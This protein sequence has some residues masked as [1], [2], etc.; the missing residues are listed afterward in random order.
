MTAPRERHRAARLPGRG[1]RV[2]AS[3]RRAST[4]RCS[5]AD[6]G[7]A[8]AASSPTNRAQA[9]PVARLARA[10]RGGPRARGRRQRR[11][12]QRRHRRA[13]A[14][15]T[16]ATMAAL[17]ARELGCRAGRGAGRLDRRDR[18]ARCRWSKRAR[19]HR[20]R[21][22]RALAA[23]AAR[24]AARA[25]LTTDTHAKEVVVEFPLGRRDARASAAM[26]KGAGMIAPNMATMLAFF[27]T[28]AA[29]EPAPAARGA[30]RGRGREP[31]PHHRRRRHLDQRHGRDPGQ[32]RAAGAPAITRR[33][34]ATTTPSAARSPRPR[35]R[36]RE[37][38]V[39]DGEG[40]TRV[41]EVRVEGA[42]HD[43]RRRPH[44]AHRGRVAAREDR[45]PRRRPEL[46]PRP[47]RRGPR[48]ASTLDIEPA[49]TS[50]WATSGSREGGAAR[51]YDEA[52]ARRARCSRIRCGSAIRLARGRR[53]SGWIW[54]CDL[55]H[56]YVDINAHYRS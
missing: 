1:G 46:G 56:G 44:R 15:P 24:D 5:S 12:R 32:R 6:A 33:R 22:R 10:P 26:A 13:R 9:A 7:C 4:S 11:L 47:G 14:S 31:Q 2:R 17:V 41:A 23:R 34:A 29:V 35:A 45:A 37:L 40:A 50:I 20:A 21:R 42:A 52:P 27:T 53:A 39:R 30:A 43:G 38:I 49:S 18:R 19:G 54:T 8:A 28:D 16:R 48:R 51:D 36:S 25:I 3:S 55:S